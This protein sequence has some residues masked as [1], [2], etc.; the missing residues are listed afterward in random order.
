[1]R[2]TRG[3]AIIMAL[4]NVSSSAQ[5][6]LDGTLGPTGA[7]PGPDYAITA[8]LGQQ[9]GGNLFHSFGQFSI[10]QGESAT[11][12]GPPSVSNI[13]S[14]VTGGQVSTIDG[15]L[16]STIPGANL[17]L[18]NPAGVL[19]RENARLDVSG[20]FHASTADYLRLGDGGRFDARMPA[21][22]LLTVA[23]VEAFGFL[24][25]TPGTIAI[26]GSFLQ[27]PDGQTLSLIGGDIAL[28][29]ATVYA[30]A[31]RLNVATVNSSG[32][33]IP[34]TH[35]LTM[36]GFARLGTLIIERDPNA[37]KVTI[38]LGEPFG[39]VALG[40]LDA[41]GAGGGAI[42]I[43]GGQWF[44]QGGR[45]FANTHGPQAGQGI[46]AAISGNVGLVD[47]WLTTE[48][49]GEGAA[50]SLRLSADNL[51]LANSNMESVTRSAGDA[52]NV[53]LVVTDT[54]TLRDGGRIFASTFAGGDAG[55]VAITANNLRVNRGLIASSANPGSSGDGGNVN[56]SI[57]NTLTLQNAGQ[58]LAGTWAGDAGAITITTGNLLVDGRGS[59][60]LTGITSSAYLDSTDSSG[61]IHLAVA[62]TLI[63]RNDGQI[64]A[65][66]DGP[67]KGGSVTITAGRAV[68]ITGNEAGL[69]VGARDAGNAGDVMLTT[70]A[71]TI[72]DGGRISATSK[73]TTG[74]N[75]LIN[76]DH[77][78][79]LNGSEISSSVFGDATTQGGDVTLN[80]INAVALDGSKVTAQARQ[81][82]GGNIVV[83]AEAFLHDAP[84]IND[85][86]N[87][88]S[89][90]S[91]NDGTV[92]NNAPTT[93]I[94]GSLAT[95]NPPYLDA[96]G[97]LSGRCGV[98]DPEEKNRFIVQGRGVLPPSPEDALPA[99][100]N[101]C[102][103]EFLTRASMT[104]E[105]APAEARSPAPT[106]S[107]FN[108][109]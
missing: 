7:L 51:F 22:T 14:R 56:L 66:T 19:F 104:Q 102:S 41:S 15:M 71:L 72:D 37:E 64:D 84:T 5:I 18:L 28:S 69:F 106:L 81:G 78:K 17:Y 49:L 54:L 26:Q 83:N 32:E 74:G 1:M 42:F 25:N 57:A 33:V 79:L 27:A 60:Y 97:Q 105:D 85:V 91:G 93:D 6:V 87:A 59:Q 67:G 68:N 107:G 99:R 12:S 9:H 61:D 80:S 50:G 29:N 36:R 90:V 86:L 95:L 44:S 62:D 35:D 75:L 8:D 103:A 20:S 10:R 63:L 45:V 39:E 70:P 89:E 31:G 40:D 13:I 82:K 73:F 4:S 23:P 2:Y 58:I 21:N 53:A 101:R 92:Q 77:L 3:W 109:R 55:S 43:R 16:R 11:F 94:S 96:T 52:G 30:P 108:N 100:I 98:I 65:F 38:D 48:T 24:G 46:D 76:A 47:A 88:S 34:T